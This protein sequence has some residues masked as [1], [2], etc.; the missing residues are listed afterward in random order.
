MKT[1][2]Q[3]GSPVKGGNHR[4]AAC[5][6]VCFVVMEDAH[7]VVATAIREGRLPRLSAVWT[8]CV[9]CGLRAQQYEHRDYTKPLEVEP[10]CRKCNHKRGPA[11]PLPAEY[12]RRAA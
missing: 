2:H 4:C 9:D 10:V 7:K 6:N 3:C 5:R 1:C 11:L 12:F 8:A